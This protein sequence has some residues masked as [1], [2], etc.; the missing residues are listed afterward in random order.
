V[1]S[2]LDLGRALP[3]AACLLAAAAPSVMAAEA[4]P[5]VRD[6]AG[7]WEVSVFH[8]PDLRGTI[9][10]ERVADGWRADLRGRLVAGKAGERGKVLFDFGQDRSLSFDPA[11]PGGAFWRQGRSDKGYNFITPV[12]LAAQGKARWAGEVAPLDDRLTLYLPVKVAADGTASTFVRNPEANVGRFLNIGR[13]E[14]V[15]GEV[16]LWGKP[17]GAQTEEVV[18][19]GPFDPDNGVVSIYMPRVGQSYEFHRIEPGQA[20]GFYP[21]VGAVPYRYAAPPARADGWPV[22]SFEDVGISRETMQRFVQHIIDLPVESNSTSDLHA[23]LIARH[24]KLVLEE[25][26]HG[27][28]RDQLHDTRS[29]GKSVTATLMGA[30]MNAGYRLSP[31][32]PVYQT[33][34]YATDDPKKRAMT[35]EHLLRQ[36]S[37]FFCDDSNDAAPGNEDTMQGQRAQ[38][39]WYRFALDLPMLNAPGSAPPVY[40]SVQPNLLGGVIA[41]ATG[42]P[43]EDLFRDLVARPMGITRYALNT[44]PTGQPYGGGGLYLAPR[45]FMKFAQVM[46]AGGTWQGRRVVSEAWAKRS[47]DALE[48]FGTRQYGYLWWSQ[49][50]PYKGRQVRAFYAA[51]NGG[52]IAMAIPE[53]DLVICFMG[54]N[55][56]DKGARVSQDVYV[57]DYILPAIND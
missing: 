39:D 41:R 32:T 24:G 23:L 47:T 27:Y 42:K 5:T 57:P 3:L 53:L 36:T 2:V 49:T 38:P 48:A 13:V 33:M 29:A 43:L 50:Y 9:V 22:G 46:L 20:T 51:G 12:A 21:R 45:D 30:A 55:F 44:Q 17:F 52:Q 26:F 6:L 19:R 16:R 34:G 28:D 56:S 15:N 54:G 4:P 8:G 10:V 7:L 1:K 25:Y 31:A 11:K 35:A 14:L 37:G 18:G 40:C